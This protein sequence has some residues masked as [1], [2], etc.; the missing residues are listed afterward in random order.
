MFKDLNLIILMENKPISIEFM[1]KMMEYTKKKYS[2]NENTQKIISVL[3]PTIISLISIY[4]LFIDTFINCLNTI[5]KDTEFGIEISRKLFLVY[6]YIFEVIIGV[7]TFIGSIIN[8]NTQNMLQQSRNNM[9]IKLETSI[10][11]LSETILVNC[12]DIIKEK[13]DEID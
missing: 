3:I 10:K 11:N 4:G 8:S 5:I 6:F 7:N 9:K 2:S 1:N 12:E 13:F